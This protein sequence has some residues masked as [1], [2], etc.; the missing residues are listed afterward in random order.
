[1]FPQHRLGLAGC[2]GVVEPSQRDRAELTVATGTE[3]SV[4]VGGQAE[5]VLVPVFGLVQVQQLGHQQVGVSQIEGTLYFA[6]AV[7]ST[8]VQFKDLLEQW[9]AAGIL[10][11][12]Q[13][14]PELDESGAKVTDLDSVNRGEA[15]SRCGQRSGG[16]V[17]QPGDPGV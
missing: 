10:L 15:G 11:L 6:R 2:A 14:D 3:V 4:A 12:A 5:A 9:Q 17:P 8:L 1:M 16:L 7:T 13:G